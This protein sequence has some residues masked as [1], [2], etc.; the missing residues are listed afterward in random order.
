M[1]SF[2]LISIKSNWALGYSRK[3]ARIFSDVHF[4]HKADELHRRRDV[5]F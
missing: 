3:S 2:V 5:S 4:W 1:R